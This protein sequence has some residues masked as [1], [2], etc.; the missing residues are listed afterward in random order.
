MAL[1]LDRPFDL[2]QVRFGLA[3]IEALALRDL[4]VVDQ[5]RE[6]DLDLLA[7]N[8]ALLALEGFVQAELDL[9]HAFVLAFVE[10]LFRFAQ[11]Q[12]RLARVR[13]DLL[14]LGD[15]VASRLEDVP[16]AVLELPLDLDRLPPRLLDELP[17]ELDVRLQ[18]GLGLRH[19]LI[20]LERLVR[21]QRLDDPRRQGDGAFREGP[22]LRGR[23]L[24][25]EDELLD[26]V[27][28]PLELVEQAGPLLED[29]PISVLHFLQDLEHVQRE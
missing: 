2:R 28:D 23:V 21:P 22:H 18:R 1:L 26:R 25:D 7:G 24:R 12:F 14:H 11:Q 10:R 17:C 6:L 29:G 5:G 15:R 3:R 20:G 19:E 8:L 9:P 27:V 16:H 13:A 4:D